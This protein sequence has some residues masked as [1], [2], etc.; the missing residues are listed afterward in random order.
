MWFGLKTDTDNI[1]TSA[2]AADVAAYGYLFS[3][4]DRN[5]VQW[6]EISEIPVAFRDY[7]IKGLEMIESKNKRLLVFLGNINSS[8]ACV[9]LADFLCRFIG[10]RW[11]AVAGQCNGTLYVILR[12][13]A[14]GVDVGRIA[15]QKLGVYG[16]AGGHQSKARG[17]IPVADIKKE[18]SGK[19]DEDAIND[20][21]H[22][23]LIGSRGRK[24]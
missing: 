6:L 7:Y 23:V 1:S 18:L 17:E 5:L 19:A 20:W 9:Q 11:V 3:K 24:K 14:Y 21:L 15:R 8:D 4:S 10:L 16:S 13:G 12:G 22:S 2:N